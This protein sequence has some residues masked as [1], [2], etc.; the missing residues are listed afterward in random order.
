MHAY[1]THTCGQLRAADV[2][3]PARLSGW[4][5]RKRD[6]GQLLFVDLR[7]HHGITQCVISAGSP[8]FEA[9]SALRPESVVTMTGAVV[10][11]G[12]DAV[13]PKLPTGEVELAVDEL[14]VAASA[15]T[16]PLQVAS[17]AEFPEDTRL[18]YRFLDLRRGKL[19]SNTP[20]RSPVD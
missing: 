5:H 9:A 13:N 6:H 1:R 12:A 20:L 16:L 11:R 19:H 10:A 2:G 7:D 14:R 4:V 18:R 8:F 3:K 17:D 15:G